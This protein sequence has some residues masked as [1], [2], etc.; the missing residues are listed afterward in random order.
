MVFTHCDEEVVESGSLAFILRPLAPQV[1]GG[2][3]RG[4]E[5]QRQQDLGDDLHLEE[6]RNKC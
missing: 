2:G 1:D 5:D 6:M 4:G 3:E